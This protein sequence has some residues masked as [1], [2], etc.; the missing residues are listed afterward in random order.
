VPCQAVPMIP[1]TATW[2]VVSNIP[3]PIAHLVLDV[4]LPETLYTFQT[5]SSHPCRIPGMV[6]RHGTRTSKHLSQY[7]STVRHTPIQYQMLLSF[8]AAWHMRK[9]IPH[10]HGFNLKLST[11]T[12]SAVCE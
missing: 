8:Q 4:N 6:Q 9:D 7:I 10:P 2:S 11:R 1:H 12:I 3:S 5:R